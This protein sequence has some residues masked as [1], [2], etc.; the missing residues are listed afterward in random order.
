MKD[1]VDKI[2]LVTGENKLG[3]IERIVVPKWWQQLVKNL[4][5]VYFE[6]EKELKYGGYDVV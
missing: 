6:V 3:V 2:H 5:N 1:L 4:N